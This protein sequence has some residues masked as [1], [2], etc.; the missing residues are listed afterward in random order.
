MRIYSIQA[1]DN[2]ING[3]WKQCIT[4]ELREESSSL[5]TSNLKPRYGIKGQYGSISLLIILIKDNKLFLG[6][7]ILGRE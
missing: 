2:L 7:S 5:K 3:V 4:V 6:K 1:W